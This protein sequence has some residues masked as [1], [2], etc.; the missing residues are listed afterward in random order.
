MFRKIQTAIING[1]FIRKMNM[2]DGK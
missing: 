2:R 1:I